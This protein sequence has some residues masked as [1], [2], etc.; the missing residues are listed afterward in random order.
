VPVHLVFNHTPERVYARGATG[1]PV[2]HSWSVATSSPSSPRSASCGAGRPLGGRDGLA[3]LGEKCPA[4]RREM[5]PS[6]R[7]TKQSLSLCK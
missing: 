1:R 6:V 3:R 2:H 5:N 7:P 4:C